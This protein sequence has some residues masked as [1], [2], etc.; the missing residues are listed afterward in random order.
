[1]TVY[2]EGIYVK[3]IRKKRIRL[4]GYDFQYLSEKSREA[5]DVF[6]LN[7]YTRRG[8][9]LGGELSR[10]RIGKVVKYY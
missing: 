8:I 2:T 10:A 3:Y 9:R 4:F 5:R 1:M 6:P 7:V